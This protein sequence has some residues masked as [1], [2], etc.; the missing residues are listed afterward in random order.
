[1]N[2]HRMS[3][4]LV[5]AGTQLLNISGAEEALEEG[6]TSGPFRKAL[7]MEVYKKGDGEEPKIL[8]PKKIYPFHLPNC[9]LGSKGE[10]LSRSPHKP[11]STVKNIT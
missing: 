4:K 11:V 1:M 7:C 3:L 5:E 9:V 2:D 8:T 10:A 6:T